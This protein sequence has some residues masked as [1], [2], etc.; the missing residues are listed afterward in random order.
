M[1]PLHVDHQ[2]RAASCSKADQPFQEHMNKKPLTEKVPKGPVTTKL[3]KWVHATA[4]TSPL[5]RVNVHR[6]SHIPP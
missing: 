5:G 2:T 3:T 4:K 1:N 6:K